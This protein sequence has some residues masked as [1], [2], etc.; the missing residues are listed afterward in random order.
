[1]VEDERLLVKDDRLGARLCLRGDRETA[2]GD[3][4]EIDFVGVVGTVEGGLGHGEDRISVWSGRVVAGKGGD[5]WAREGREAN[6]RA[7]RPV[8]D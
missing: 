4:I 2:F 8:G 1:M 5:I 6:S 3:G 7:S